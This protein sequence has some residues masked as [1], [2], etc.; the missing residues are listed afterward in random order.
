MSKGGIALLLGCLV[1]SLPA[2]AAMSGEIEQWLEAHNSY[3]RLHGVPEV[4]WSATVAASAQSFIDS[5]PSSHSS[6]D[7]GEN[8]AWATYNMP[9]THVVELWYSEEEKYDYNNPGFSGGTGHFTQV[10]WKST[11]EIG[12]A[13]RAGCA[14]SDLFGGTTHTAWVCQYNPPGNNT[15]TFEDNVFPPNTNPVPEPDPRPG[16]DPSPDPD[17][18]NQHGSGHQVL[19]TILDLLL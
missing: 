19:P 12:C 7:Y 6:S 16:P 2:G 3:R 10:V 4:T 15:R 9:V 5:C 18:T 11:T 1:C 14:N 17:G 13:F 8:L